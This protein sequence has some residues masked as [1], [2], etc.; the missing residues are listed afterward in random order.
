MRRV[1]AGVLISI[2]LRDQNSEMRMEITG[3]VS[4]ALCKRKTKKVDSLPRFNEISDIWMW[5]LS[6]SGYH[7]VL[8][9]MIME[10]TL[11][12]QLLDGLR[13]SISWTEAATTRPDL[14]A[15]IPGP[16]RP[17]EIADTGLTPVNQRELPAVKWSEA[18]EAGLWTSPSMPMPED[19]SQI[20]A[21]SQAL[22]QPHCFIVGPPGTGKTTALTNAVLGTILS[23]EGPL[24][25]LHTAWTK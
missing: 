20:M 7:R 16:M 5:R 11:V 2:S 25:T 3:V 12:K 6:V 15:V 10:N 19:P 14:Y 13:P 4:H 24:K 17:S 18:L 22:A 21:L 23:H 1:R 8:P 9:S